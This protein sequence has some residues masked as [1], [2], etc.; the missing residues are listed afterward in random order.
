[1]PVVF[2]HCH[3]NV[4]RCFRQRQKIVYFNFATTHT[5]SIA[6]MDITVQGKIR[7]VSRFLPRERLLADLGPQEVDLYRE[8]KTEAGPERQR[9]RGF[10]PTFYAVLFAL[11]PPQGE[12][13][14]RASVSTSGLLVIVDRSTA[15][16]MMIKNGKRL[17]LSRS[18]RMQLEDWL[19][20]AL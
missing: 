11:D 13:A 8:E 16:S 20:E 6:S 12:I 9:T 18:Y 10:H 1:M 4:E 3:K 2:G 5:M 14:V 7:T 19:R 15:A 17:P